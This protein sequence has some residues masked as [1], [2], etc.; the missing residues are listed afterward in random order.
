[1]SVNLYKHLLKQ[2]CKQVSS[3]ISSLFNLL[4]DCSILSS[5]DG[6]PPSP[7]VKILDSSQ[8]GLCQRC[9]VEAG[10]RTQLFFPWLTMDTVQ[11]IV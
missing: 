2:S 11:L 9:Q 5:F 1:M 4:L 7:I 10:K 6:S 8:I 3:F